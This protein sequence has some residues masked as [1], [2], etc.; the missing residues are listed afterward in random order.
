MKQPTDK[1]Y[2]IPMDEWI[3]RLPEDLKQDAV[4]LWHLVA[5]GRDSFD[6]D[7]TEL[8]E[9]VRKSIQVLLE[10]GALPVVADIGGNNDWRLSDAYQ[11]GTGDTV[12]AILADWLNLGCDPDIGG[13]WF[14]LPERF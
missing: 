3:I 10:H 13:L 7:S 2:G 11:T 4:A 1:Y 12:D 8:V 14:S 6:L 5:G 9:F